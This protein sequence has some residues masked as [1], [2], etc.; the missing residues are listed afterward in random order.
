[1]S[2]IPG[3]R[4]INGSYGQ[5]WWDGDLIFE[6]SSFEAKIT[7]SREDVKMAG[8]LDIDSKITNLKGEGSFKIKKVFSRGITSLLKAWKDG[9]DPRS[10]LIGKLAD[11]DTK[12]EAKERVVIDNVWFNELT[13]MQFES[14][15]VLEHEFK[16]GF[17][18]SDVDFPDTIP[19]KEG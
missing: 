19:V 10:Q 1:M 9:N 16:F 8:T 11:P 13:L 14:G 17:T 15:K 2:K 7:P 12:H 6:I 4:V 18:P 3:Y 5:L